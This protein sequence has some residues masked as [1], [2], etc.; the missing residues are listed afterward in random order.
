VTG[1]CLTYAQ[2]RHDFAMYANGGTPSTDIAN[3]GKETWRTDLLRD[4]P[5]GAFDNVEYSADMTTA[6]AFTVPIDITVLGGDQPV[7][8]YISQRSDVAASQYWVLQNTAQGVFTLTLSTVGYAANSNSYNFNIASLLQFR[9]M[10]EGVHVYFC[11]DSDGAITWRD[12]YAVFA[13]RGV[14]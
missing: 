6:A 13:A 4:G 8:A 10:F 9:R 12:M 11:R 2:M 14:T 1:V 5:D 7:T 3:D